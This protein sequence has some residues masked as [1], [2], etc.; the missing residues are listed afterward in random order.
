MDVCRCL[1]LQSYTNECTTGPFNSRAGLGRCTCT[2]NISVDGASIV[3]LTCNNISVARHSRVSTGELGAA[4]CDGVYCFCG[5]CTP[6]RRRAQDQSPER[7]RPS[8]IAHRLRQTFYER[9]HQMS[10]ERRALLRHLDDASEWKENV[11]DGAM[12]MSRY[13]HIEER[14]AGTRKL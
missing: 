12:Q 13:L 7:A 14:H 11:V 6:S 8:R 1:L 9:R 3:L 10:S 2:C 5:V 4:W